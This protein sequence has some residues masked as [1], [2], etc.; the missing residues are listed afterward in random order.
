MGYAIYNNGIRVSKFYKTF[1]EA[2]EELRGM[3]ERALKHNQKIS[4]LGYSSFAV[5]D[6]DVNVLYISQS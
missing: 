4:G 1:N 3:Y 2:Y 6:E 5:Y